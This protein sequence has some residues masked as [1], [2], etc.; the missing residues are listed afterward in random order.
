MAVNDDDAPRLYSHALRVYKYMEQRASK[1]TGALIFEGK[2]TEILTEA[3]LSNNYYTPIFRYLK[4][5]GYITQIRRGGGQGLSVFQLNGEPEPT[6]YMKDMRRSD[7]GRSSSD[8]ALTKV[9]ELVHEIENIKL[10]VDGHT[11]ALLTIQTTL[12][13]LLSGKSAKFLPQISVVDDGEEPD[14]DSE[15]ENDTEYDFKDMTEEE[16]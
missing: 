8:R 9:S 15:L 14:F 10:L 11:T 2:T 5:G 12:V 13:N 4:G 1:V 7:A 16:E 3:G 6:N